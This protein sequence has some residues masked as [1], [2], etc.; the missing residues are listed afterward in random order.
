MRRPSLAEA[1]TCSPEVGCPGRTLLLRAVLHKLRMAEAAV[2]PGVAPLAVGESLV[3]HL[4]GVLL[5]PGARRRVVRGVVT[6]RAEVRPIPAVA[7]PAKRA[8]ARR[9]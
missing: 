4:N 7:A 9:Q 6:H 5:D 3:L 2:R 8:I 1:G